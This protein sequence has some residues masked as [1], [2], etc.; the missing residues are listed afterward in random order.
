MAPVPVSGPLV[1]DLWSSRRC[2][3]KH[4]EERP[5]LGSL[6]PPQA[7]P[8]HPAASALHSRSFP[9]S[10]T[11]TSDLNTTCPRLTS[12]AQH[13]DDVSYPSNSNGTAAPL[14]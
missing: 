5:L 10:Q 8:W 3:R 14:K 7:A 4:R 11:Y 13:K 1:D 6:G 12:T 9:P 2:R